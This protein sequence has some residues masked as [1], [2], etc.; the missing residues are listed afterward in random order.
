[1]FFQRRIMSS[2]ESYSD[3]VARLKREI[4]TADA[5]ILRR[6]TAFT[7]CTQDVIMKRAIC[8]NGDIKQVFSE[9][10]S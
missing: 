8:I 9:I 5:M 3:S 7:I 1:M 2:T 4:E 6:S 10:A